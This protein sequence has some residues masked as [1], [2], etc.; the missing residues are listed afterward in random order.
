MLMEMT[1][2]QTKSSRKFCALRIM[3]FMHRIRGWSSDLQDVFLK[4]KQT[5]RIMKVNT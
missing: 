5:P 3:R 1:Q 4:N 2:A